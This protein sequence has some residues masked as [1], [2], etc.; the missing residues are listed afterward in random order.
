MIVDWFHPKWIFCT[1]RLTYNC[2]P[3]QALN[4]YH[5]SDWE[6]QFVGVTMHVDFNFVLTGILTRYLKLVVW[7]VVHISFNLVIYPFELLAPENY[8][9]LELHKTSEIESICLYCFIINYHYYIDFPCCFACFLQ[10]KLFFPTVT[11][12]K[13]KSSRNSSIGNTVEFVSLLDSYMLWLF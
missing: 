5:L 3:E 2:S 12:A 7:D 9:I 1:L 10:L 6:L 8:K 4:N 11:F 13:P